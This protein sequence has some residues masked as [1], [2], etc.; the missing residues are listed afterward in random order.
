MSM[1]IFCVTACGVGGRDGDDDGATG[2]TMRPGENC[3]SCHGF[4]VAGTV[5]GDAGAAASEGIENA[6]IILK[7]A[8]G[9][10]LTLTSNSAGNFYS[11]KSLKFPLVAQITRNGV[12]KTMTQ[13]VTSGG[14]ATC[15]ASPPGSGAPGRLFVAP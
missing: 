10:S 12:T 9:V 13:G 4:S 1:V 11:N 3:K 6:S 7:D 5:F 2:P 8:D 15:H 14:C